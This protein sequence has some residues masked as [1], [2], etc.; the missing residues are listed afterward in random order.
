MGTVAGPTFGGFVVEH[1]AWQFEFWWTVAL[2]C[3][4]ALLGRTIIYSLSSMAN[5]ISQCFSTCLKLAS[6]ETVA[7]STQ[8]SQRAMSR[9]ESP[10]SSLGHESLIEM[11]FVKP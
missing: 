9:T 2:Q 10:L 3:A 7:E 4:V 8:D 6:H 1:V 11:V 5:A